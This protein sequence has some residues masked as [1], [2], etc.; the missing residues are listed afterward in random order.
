M[1]DEQDRELENAQ[2]DKAAVDAPAE[3]GE[4]SPAEPRRRLFTGSYT[5]G[6]DAKGRM[7]VPID[8]RQML[9]T[10]FVVAPTLDFKSI[11]LYPTEEWLKIE[12]R[13][14]ALLALDARAQRLID[15]FNKYSYDNSETDAQGRLLLPQKLRAKYLGDARDVDING[16]NTHV[17][18]IESAKGAEEDAAFEREIPDPLAFMAQLQH[19]ANKD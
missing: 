3:S 2:P 6:L 1:S 11:A 16:A 18:V 19:A 9:G 13:L 5:H 12:S 8:F 17:R 10:P 7:I 15:Q 14:E 4:Q